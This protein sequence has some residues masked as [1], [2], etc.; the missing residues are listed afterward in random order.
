MET[1]VISVFS[2]QRTL[3][4]QCRSLREGVAIGGRAAAE[5]LEALEWPGLT[6][7]FYAAFTPYSHLLSIY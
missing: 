2:P 4:T 6:N 3:E 1:P 5:W 7:G